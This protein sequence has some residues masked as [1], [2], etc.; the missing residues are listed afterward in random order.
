MC[1]RPLKLT[2]L[3]HPYHLN[4]STSGFRDIRSNV[5]FSEAFHDDPGMALT[6]FRQ[7]QICSSVHMNLEDGFKVN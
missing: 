1:H 2:G 6:Y 4:K 7:G 5:S 3:S